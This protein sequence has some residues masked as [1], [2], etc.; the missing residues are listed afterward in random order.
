MSPSCVYALH[1]KNL[2]E[3]SWLSVTSLRFRILT[4]NTETLKHSPDD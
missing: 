1:W 4:S 3:W 2:S